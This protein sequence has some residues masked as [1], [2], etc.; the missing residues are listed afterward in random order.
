MGQWNP[1]QYLKFENE[2][3]QP[4]VDLA[5]RTIHPNPQ[6][7]IDVGCGPGNS[8][9]VLK[10]KWPDAEITG[11]D[12]SPEMIEKAGKDYPDGKWIVKDAAKIDLNRSYDIVFSNAAIQ[13][14]SDHEKLIERFSRILN[15]R[16]VLAVQVPANSRSPLHQAL[17]MVSSLPKWNEYT[18]GCRDLINYRDADYYYPILCRLF[19]R[20]TIWETAYYHIL[21]SHQDMMEWYKGTGMKPFLDSIP[22]KKLKKEFE[23]EVL[24]ACRIFYP[25]QNNG[26]ILFPFQRLFFTGCK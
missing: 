3:T 1:D 2:R 19:S 24:D 23:K 25:V 10:E 14:V 15:P 26:K 7:I 9:R 6:T 8:T 4:A 5:A 17:T 21:N 13:W 16:G 18:A 11:I 22:D 12:S 20:I